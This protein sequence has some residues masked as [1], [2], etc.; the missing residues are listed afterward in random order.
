MSVWA[1]PITW[2]NGAI[3]ATQMNSLRDNLNFLKGALDLL[4]A[5]TT[6]DTGTLMRLGIIRGA[7]GNVALSAAVSG[8]ANDRFA[9][10]ADGRHEWGSGSAVRDTWLF[11]TSE[12]ELSL[13][14]TSQTGLHLD[15]VF[16]DTGTGGYI[17]IL[18]GA[19][20]PG[21]AGTN[22]LRLFA[23]DNGS[24][25]TQLCIKWNSGEITVLGTQP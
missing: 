11:R 23:R 7:V 10:N 25:K 24:G 22:T 17:D 20:N 19:T 8:D 5:S 9:L 16:L 4:T 1:T 3:T 15:T 6:A 18:E 14:G 13:G 21:G 2:A 12:G